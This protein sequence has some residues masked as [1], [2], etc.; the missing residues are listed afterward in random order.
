MPTLRPVSAINGLKI[1][2]V[3][4]REDVRNAL[5]AMFK[6]L[7]AEVVTA[8]DGNAA[9]HLFQ[10]HACSIVL[11]D[12]M[13]PGLAVEILCERIKTKQPHVPIIVMTGSE[14]AKAVTLCEN[15]RADYFLEKPFT[16]QNAVEAISKTLPRTAAASR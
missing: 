12:I 10:E 2:V 9:W 14:I 1:L 6:A 3:E 8:E 7:G 5:Q 16:M 13:M 11:T 15:S 4:D